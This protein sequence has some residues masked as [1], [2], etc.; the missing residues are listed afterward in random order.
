MA[1]DSPE[2][3]AHVTKYARQSA[4]YMR[5]AMQYLNAHL[6]TYTTYGTYGYEAPFDNANADNVGT[7]GES[8]G[9]FI[10][11]AP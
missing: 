4:H 7:D 10:M 11:G 1:M 6:T 8:F 5:Q 2:N 9:I 3:E